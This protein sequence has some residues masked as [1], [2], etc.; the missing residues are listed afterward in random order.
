MAERRV[1]RISELPRGEYDFGPALLA[2]IFFCSA[3]L[4]AL[5]HA[6]GEFRE[7]A[8]ACF[9]PFFGKDSE[10]KIPGPIYFRPKLDILYLDSERVYGL[11]LE[12]PDINKTDSIAIPNYLKPNRVWSGDASL[13]I[14]SST[15]CAES[16]P[17]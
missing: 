7:F 6:C 3:H 5:L 1:L 14:A 11:A 2:E 10:G 16:R 12:N 9:E 13:R 8:L 17:C 15:T 4:P